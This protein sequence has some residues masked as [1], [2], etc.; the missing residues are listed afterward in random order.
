MP[1]SSAAKEL[2]WLPH[3]NPD[4]TLCPLHKTAQT[5]CLMGDGPVP[6]KIMLVGEA[7]GRREDD[8]ERPFSGAAGK[9][10]DRAL[11]RAGFQRDSIYITNSVRCRPPDNRA[12]SRGEIKACSGYMA[13]EIKAVAP[14]IIVPMGNAALQATLGKTGI[15]KLRGAMIEHAGRKY[16]PTYHPAAC[17]HNP[18][19]E[20]EFFN[21]WQALARLLKGEDQ[22]PRTKV[23]LIQGFKPLRRFLDRLALVESPIAFDVETSAKNR[24]DE[25]GLQP[26][27]PDGVIE[28]AA[29]SWEPGV[30]YTLALEHPEAQW[31]I[32]LELVYRALNVALDGKKLVGH[33]V[34]FD[35]LWLRSKGV[36]GKAHFDTL[37]AAHLLDEN[38]SNSLKPLARTFLGAELY[39]RGV[40]FKAGTKLNTLAV[41]NGKDADYTLRLYHIFREEL[42]KQPRLLRLFKLLMMPACNTLV[43][44]ERRGFPV[45]VERL[46]VRHREILEKI[47]DIERQLLEFVPDELKRT[48][49]N[50]RSPL[51]LAKWIFGYL[52]LP[53]LAIGAKSNRPSTAE[54][55]LLQ[56]KDRHPAVGLLMELRKWNKYES[57]YTRNWISRVAIAGKPRLYTSYNLSGTVTGRLS[58]NMQQVPRDTY[59]RGIIGARPGWRLIEAD[60]SQIELRI[61]AML[62]RDTELTNAFNNN[63]DPHMQTAMSV[64]HRPASEIS[65]EERKMAKAVNFGFLYGMGARKFQIYAKEKYDTEVTEAESKAYRNAF[66]ARYRGLPAW[67]DRQRRLVRTLGYVQSPIG[68][69][70]H[71][72]TIHSSDEGVVAEAERQAINSPVQGLASDFT[73]L[74][75]VLLH[76]QLDPKVARILGNLHDA[77]ILEVREDSADD[78]AALVKRTMENLPLKRYFGFKPTVPILADVQIIQHWG[79]Q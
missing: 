21:D 25:G 14:E 50:F 33:N 78:V 58:S 43:E 29:F 26:W 75:M 79:G 34:K 38:R 45:D 57:T 44:V 16:Y 70:R 28:T 11:E 46:K 63:E 77:V 39:E 3:R 71:L 17:L 22:K 66:F 55:V 47:D 72:P 73:V 69:I 15:T 18:A 52:G 27:A 35:L 37:L 62:S 6:A 74:S 12:P 20:P 49:P 61:A 67:H 31:D 60:F 9:L 2:V 13:T 76:G 8:I 54:S 56:I 65:K 1:V 24:R 40:D 42:K 53:I 19:L 41:Y 32:P 5:V 51:F 30:A 59:I 64:L 68:R 7:P 36:A 48:K 4:C 23:F 10:L